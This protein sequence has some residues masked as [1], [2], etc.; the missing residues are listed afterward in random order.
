MKPVC[1]FFLGLMTCSFFIAERAF[2][3]QEF[4]LTGVL[5]DDATK[6]RIALAEITNKRTRYSVGSNDLGIFVIKAKIGDTLYIIKRNFDDLEVVVRTE[7]L[8]LKMNRGATLNEVIIT[9]QSKNQALNETA[10]D[11]KNKGSFFAGRPPARLLSPF[12]GSPLTF[13]YELFGK[14]PKN[15][16][17]FS[18]MRQ[19]EMEQS[20]IDKFY[21]QSIISKNTG[22]KD[23]ELF[24][25]FVTYRP[26]YEKTVNWASYDGTKWIIDCYKKYLETKKSPL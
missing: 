5:S 14:T 24:S 17:R 9:G 25:F 2:A 23:Q 4:K 12:G 18:N 15:A 13:L 16:R 7:N 3:Q 6:N 10:Q 8:L 1:L 21:N 19:E 22:L 11:F 20:H 26:D